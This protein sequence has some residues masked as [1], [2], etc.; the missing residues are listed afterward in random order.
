ML[1][2]LFK[3]ALQSPFTL[4]DLPSPH[5]RKRWT[6]TYKKKKKDKVFVEQAGL[7][8]RGL[9]SF[10]FLSAGVGRHAP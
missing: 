2:V 3:Y 1:G 7:G 10:E 5:Q 6:D 8:L 9:P 4:S